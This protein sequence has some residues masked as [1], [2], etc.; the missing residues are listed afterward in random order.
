MGNLKVIYSSPANTIKS[1][2]SVIGIAPYSA[3]HTIMTINPSDSGKV[4]FSYNGSR[5][6][7]SPLSLDLSEKGHLTA[8]QQS[9]IQI[10]STEHLLSALHGLNINSVDINISQAP[11]VPAIDSSAD[12]YTKLLWG[13]GKIQLP[14]SQPVLAITEEFRIADA[15]SDSYIEFAPN[16]NGL[17]VTT[18]IDF[19]NLIGHQEFTINLTEQSFINELAWARTFFSTPVSDDPQKWAFFRSVLPFLSEKIEESPIIVF[20]ER[21]FIINLK[22]KDEPVRHKTL[23]F[24]GDIYTLGLPLFARVKLYKPGHNLNHLAVNYLFEY[25]KSLFENIWNVRK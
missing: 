4:S 17:E 8:L 20:D 12:N 22:K 10:K 24:I 13:T 7:L 16:D 18:V 21:R 1:T 14:F 2:V 25:N 3:K 19:T 15:E 5:I 6:P 11:E 23:D 9:G